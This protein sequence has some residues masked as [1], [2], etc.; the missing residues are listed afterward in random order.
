MANQLTANP[1]TPTSG[2]TE[3]IPAYKNPQGI[4]FFKED[5]ESESSFSAENVA[6]VVSKGLEAGSIVFNN[7]VPA[8]SEAFMDLLKG[9]TGL[10][11]TQ[12]TQ[13]EA[14][15][16]IQPEQPQP[17]ITQEDVK[18]RQLQRD[19]Q[20]SVNRVPLEKIQDLAQRAMM[21]SDGAVSITDVQ[22]EVF[23][24]VSIPGSS[25]EAINKVGI[26]DVM[27]TVDKRSNQI[28]AAVD[29]NKEQNLTS[30]T[31]AS[32]IQTAVEG[33]SGSVGGA[34]AN[35]SSQNVG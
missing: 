30:A 27:I 29:F 11:E 24:S 1:P 20:D 4:G 18:I 13:P 26:S 8:G 14:S 35:L 15:Q 31:Q 23:Q 16:F 12:P 9:V 6:E 32:A 25:T 17:I 33:G 28:K 21:M 10:G 19:I 34:T 2:T 22:G 5:N 7:L 3:K